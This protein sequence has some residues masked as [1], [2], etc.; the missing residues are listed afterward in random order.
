MTTLLLCRHGRTDWNDDGRYQGRADVPLN[1]LGHQQADRLAQDL[2]ERHL[3][4]VYSSALQR[5][6]QTAQRIAARHGLQVVTDARLNEIDQGLW[7][8]LLVTEIALSYPELFQ[9]WQTAPLEVRLPEGETVHEVAIR[10]LVALGEIVG[11][12]PWSTVCVVSHR[13]LMLC[14][15]WALEG[16]DLASAARDLPANG[17]IVELRTSVDA[18]AAALARITQL[19]DER[20]MG[21]PAD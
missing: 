5:G 14:L 18:V 6:V 15:L 11:R 20:L 4:A 2:R 9:R 3:D 1:P 13:M 16:F 7:E 21:A 17:Q 19:S 8:G 12:H 10:A